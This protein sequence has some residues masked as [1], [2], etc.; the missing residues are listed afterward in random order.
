MLITKIIK[1]MSE[2]QNQNNNPLEK[3]N[4]QVI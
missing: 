1:K 2:I 3:I 4:I